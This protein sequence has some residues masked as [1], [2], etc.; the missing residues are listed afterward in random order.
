MKRS[1]HSLIIAALV[2]VVAAGC[3]T[4]PK[5]VV[6]LSDQIGKDL[7]ALHESYDHLIHEYYNRMRA[8]R[9]AY[10]D[11][12]WYPRF[13]ENWMEDGEVRAIAAGEK[14]WSADEDR[15]IPV[16][17]G[18]D[19][20]KTERTLRDWLDYALYAYET[21]KDDLTASLDEDEMA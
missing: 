9:I 5:D 7:T 3:A 10:L 12:V 19:P 18:A 20:I 1:I 6:R 11:D 15:L 16:T 8:E 17:A 2:A 13:I 21:K 4:V 14:I